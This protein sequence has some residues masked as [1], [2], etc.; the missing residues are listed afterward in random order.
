MGRAWPHAVEKG[1]AAKPL[2]LRML[3]SLLSTSSIIVQLLPLM[4]T[5]K[6]LGATA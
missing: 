2:G 4:G 3:E 6:A 5:A 1:R